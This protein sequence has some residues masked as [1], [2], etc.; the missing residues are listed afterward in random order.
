MQTTLSDQTYEIDNLKIYLIDEDTRQQQVN[1]VW[2]DKTNYLYRY[3]QMFV[4]NQSV[5]TWCI[6]AIVT[7]TV[8]HLIGQ[9]CRP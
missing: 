2:D 7:V 3:L 6:M 8:M 4:C 5:R 1:L 9:T